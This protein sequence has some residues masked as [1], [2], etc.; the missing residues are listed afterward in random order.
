M[1]DLYIVTLETKTKTGLNQRAWQGRA[2][3]SSEARK[4]AQN[5]NP[6]YKAVNVVNTSKR[7]R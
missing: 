2:S 3:S 1:D 4:M 5:K 7:S 6:G